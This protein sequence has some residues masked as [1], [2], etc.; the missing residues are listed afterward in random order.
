M[1]IDELSPIFKELTQHPVSFLG[2]FFSGV[3]R[4]NLADDPVKSWLDKQ[5]GS[6]TY[7]STGTEAHNGKAGGPQ[8]ITID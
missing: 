7:T 3:F 5:T 4:L 1:F 8:Q 2:G 6:T